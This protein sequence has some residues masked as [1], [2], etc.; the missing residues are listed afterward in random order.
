MA[1]IE[2]IEGIGKAYAQKLRGMGIASVEALLEKGATPKGRQDIADQ[3]GISGKLILK[4][5][6]HADLFRITGVGEEYAELLEACG[7]DTVVELALRRADN[8]THTLI[9]V[10]KTRP[11]MVRRLPTESQVEG[12]IQEAKTLPRVVTY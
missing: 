9:E 8:L 3:T 5:V 2:V 4:W 11:V 10:D 7:V 12:W 1:K 6:N